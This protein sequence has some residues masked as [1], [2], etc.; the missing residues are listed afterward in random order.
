MS[1]PSHLRPLSRFD[2]LLAARRLAAA[3]G[4]VGLLA[5]TAACSRPA[6]APEPV[7]AVRT[8]MVAA[9]ST[10]LTRQFAA[11][12]RART[13]S[14][15]GFRVGGKMLSR[16]VE[17]GDRVKV[18][19]VLAQ[20]D[21]TDLRLGQVAARA[22][23]RAAEAN[24]A[25]ATAELRRNSELKAQGFI[26]GVELERRETSL[27]A[28]QSQLDQARAQASVQ[29]NQAGY[30]ALVATAAG[31]VTAV[32]AEPGAVLAAGAP[33][34]RLA[35]DGPR[36]AVFNVPEDAVLA[37][38]AMQGRAGMLAVR[39]W[40]SEALLPATVREVAAAADPSTRTFLVRAGLGTAAVQLG[41]TLTVLVDGP[42]TE[43]VAKL[44]LSAL[45][46]EQGRSAVWL[47]DRASMT[48]KLQ[49][50]AVAGADANSVVIASGLAPGQTVV[51]AGVH[52]LSPGQKVKLYE[53][54][55][56]IEAPAP[57]SSR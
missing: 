41:Q 25:L 27:A 26:S 16:S 45:F 15:L 33:V 47:V 36:D 56:A 40:G 43:G 24:H 53:A 10:G 37:F 9:E 19:Q 30:A 4:L 54:A 34:M 17:P 1:F 29:G 35:H 8:L 52:V 6:P 3:L 44:P 5:L 32:D 21:P 46:Q 7:R 38:R 57:A 42:R 20:L 23:L 55:P 13:E 12:V 50:V 14:R 48:V 31:V 51:T 11:D 39:T 49:P 18:G 28:A 2:R 22:A